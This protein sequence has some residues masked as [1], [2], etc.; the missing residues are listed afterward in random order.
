[1]QMKKLFNYGVLFFVVVFAS[2]LMAF[3]SYRHDQKTIGEVET[4]VF[5]NQGLFITNETVNNLLKQNQ[6]SLENQLNSAINL[7]TL[8]GRIAKHPLVEEA[9]VYQDVNGGLGV[10]VYQKTPVLRVY[11]DDSSYYL[12][13]SGNTMPL[14]ENFTARVPMYRGPW[15]DQVKKDVYSLIEKLNEDLFWSRELIGVSSTKEDGYLLHTRTGNH[16][17]V[18]GSLK[19]LDT[20]LDKYE[21]FLATAMNQGLAKEYKKVN[22]KF[23]NQVVCSK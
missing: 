4:K 19:G 17:V 22:L 7:H 16:L 11:A 5:D 13:D 14:S 8:E 10:E 23:N 2:F 1:M 3:S 12:D 21:I 9:L 20:K 15:N 18:V 6:D